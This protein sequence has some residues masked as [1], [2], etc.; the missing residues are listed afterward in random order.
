MGCL[1]CGGRLQQLFAE[2]CA[3][4]SQPA[5]RREHK[6][7]RRAGLCT[8]VE[9]QDRPH[10]SAAHES[11]WEYAARAGT[12]TPFYFGDT[13]SIDQANYD[14]VDFPASYSAPGQYRGTP[15]PVGSFP[16]NA[17]GLS[18]MSGNV[19]EWVQDCWNESYAAPHLPTRG[20]AWLSGDCERRVVRGGAF[21]NSPAYAR[22][23]FRFWEVASLRSALVGFRVAR[24]P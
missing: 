24:E 17:F 15:T 5:A 11:E 13:V 9:R 23:A 2:R 14:P 7:E 20:Q 4:G 8:L 16:A 22:S 1:R 3:L 10:L 12:T 21:N 19:W 6:L 18:D